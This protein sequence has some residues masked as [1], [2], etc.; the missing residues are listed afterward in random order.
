MPRYPTEHVQPITVREM[1][2]SKRHDWDMELIAGEAGLERKI[3]TSEI[4]R[5]GL[6]LAGYYDVFSVERVQLIGLTE[7]TYL[8]SLSAED[9]VRRLRRTLEFPIPC[10]IVTRSLDI[11]PEIIEV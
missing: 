9:R 5:P 2:E 10:F 4:S 8:N 6:A 1:F 11:P 3:S 7:F